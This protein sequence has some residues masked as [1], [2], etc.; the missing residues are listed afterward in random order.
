M[1]LMPVDEARQ[2][3][4][5]TARPLGR[6]VEEPLE[7][8]L[9]GWLAAPVAARVTVP[10]HDNSA[11]DGIAVRRAD[12]GDGTVSLPI[13]LRVPAGD[14]PGELAPGG[15]A[16]IFTGAPV[17][18]GA[19]TVLMQEDCVFGDG[20]VTPPAADGVRTGQN[21]RPAG[22]DSRQGEVV[23]AAGERITPMAIGL[24]ASVGVATLP[25]RRLRVTVISSGDELVPP[26][27]P[28]GP[29]KIYNSNGP[30]MSTLLAQ[31]GFTEV[32]ALWLPD[33]RARTREQLDA[34]LAD[35]PDLVLASGGVSVGEEDHLRAALE[36]RGELDFWRLAIKPGKPFTFGRL[37][38][39]GLPFFG[40]PGNPSAVVVCYLTLVLPYLR[41]C[42]GAEPV[43]P[44]PQRL[45]ADFTVTRP[46]PRQEY[47]RVR[48]V[49]RDGQ[50]WLQR[51]PNQ[52]SG[53]LS[54]AVWADGLAVVPVD[55]TVAAGD[56]LDY[57]PF[58]DLLA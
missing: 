44:V 17:P 29:G 27:T 23:L 16:R 13:T 48:R 5:A 10:P 53:M 58:A 43:L 24:A 33:D 31:S 55:A 6:V 35:P 30:L 4:L 14:P 25:V 3:L 2:R 32:A 42:L 40:L 15:A 38:D 49:E 9:G 21:I 46:G 45:P 56:P 34:L 47:L 37:G 22:Q 39:A 1:T 11:V 20:T 26:G 52:S 51:H 19:D 7:R 12:L 50:A 36:E 8:A 57:Y 18:A 41:R 54:S 28:A